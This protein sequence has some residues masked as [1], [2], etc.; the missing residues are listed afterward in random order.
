MTTL[1][2]ALHQHP[3]PRQ[4]VFATNFSEACHAA[5]PL[6]AQW[7]DSL[8]A[9][10]TLLHVHAAGTHLQAKRSLDSFFAE[11]AHYPNSERVLRSGKPAEAI[12]EYCRSQPNSLLVM[13][14]STRSSLPRPLHSSLRAKVLHDVITPMLTLPHTDRIPEPP[15]T[16]GHVACWISGQETRLDHVREAAAL[17]QRRGAELHLMHALP[18]VSEGMLIDALYSD[19]P[20]SESVAGQR[21]ADIASQLGNELPIR[22]HIGTGEPESVL[23]KLLK[24]TQA[25]IL[26]VDRGAVMR[27]RLM[28]ASFNSKLA[29]SPC[30]LICVPPRE[31]EG[32]DPMLPA[33]Q[34]SVFGA[35]PLPARRLAGIAQQPARTH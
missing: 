9:K 23:R 28:Q 16:G 1:N 26:V 34:S 27:K 14:P 6:V 11:A 32:R 12:A 3:F 5:I 25:S 7:V 8:Q 15:S 24:R 33:P 29:D 30:L 35:R 2:S 4:L 22:L 13:P 20:L 31:A 17:A 19:R 10:L 21:L 18:E